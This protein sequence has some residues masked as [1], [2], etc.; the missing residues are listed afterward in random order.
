MRSQRPW[1]TA[2][3]LALTTLLVALP[4]CGNQKPV[5]DLARARLAG[6]TLGDTIDSCV[7]EVGEPVEQSGG[8]D[9]PTFSYLY[10]DRGLQV[11]FDRATQRVIAIGLVVSNDKRIPEVG[12]FTP[13]RSPITLAELDPYPVRTEGPLRNYAFRS[14]RAVVML[15]PDEKGVA[16]LGLGTSRVSG[17][18]PL[19]RSTLPLPTAD[20]TRPPA[21]PRLD[22]D[23]LTPGILPFVDTFDR[24]DGPIGNGWHSWWGSAVDDPKVRLEGGWLVSAGFTTKAAGI[25]RRL[26]VTF[27][28]SF[29]FDYKPA[30]NRPEENGG[31]WVIAFNAPPTSL[32]WR[33]VGFGQSPCRVLFWLSSGHGPMIRQYWTPTGER[34][35]DSVMGRTSSGAGQSNQDPSLTSRIRGRVWNDLRAEIIVTQD[36][37]GARPIVSTFRFPAPTNA[38]PEAPGDFLYFGNASHTGTHYLDNLEIKQEIE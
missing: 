4:G 17:V 28:L 9:L 38:A 21:P 11:T 26:P 1:T 12:K 23:A 35:T 14:W 24:P 36:G 3:L 22:L 7:A 20:L 16:F 25:F 6:V 33:S 15:T 8:G 10:P 34:I 31:A 29:S 37:G 19:A 5:T 27:P 32:P 13:A 30:S 2:L 18:P